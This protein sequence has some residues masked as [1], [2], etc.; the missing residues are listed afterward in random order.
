MNLL[1][2][3]MIA[4]FLFFVLCGVYKGFLSTLLSIGA[5]ILSWLMAYI[6]LP[7]GA[8]GVKHN[9]ALFNTMLYYTEGSEYVKD[10][11]LAR[12]GI[13]SIGTEKLNSILSNASLPYPMGK[14]ITANV[15]KE[16]FAGDGIVSLGDYF[17]QTIVCVF[18]N[19][20]I[21]LLLFAVIRAVIGFII[22]GVDYAWT[23][24]QLRAGDTALSAGLGLIRGILAM[25]LL[26]MLLPPLLIVLQ[27]RLPFI[28][29]LVEESALARFFYRSNFLL[30]MM[31]GS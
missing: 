13:S 27:G 4:V 20:L 14:Q 29:E 1:D 31:P 6:L 12:Q 28:T 2:L 19:I 22:S 21:F 18:I 9:Q 17:N 10:V 11:E 3:A 30:S 5:Y 24:P 16:A 25:F 7:L 15:A 26:F 8:N 23:F